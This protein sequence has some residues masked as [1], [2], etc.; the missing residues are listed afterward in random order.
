MFCQMLAA[1][2]EATSR[3]H[4]GTEAAWLY[5]LGLGARRSQDWI[6]WLLLHWSCLGRLFEFILL[7]SMVR[8]L[9]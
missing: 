5:Q 9:G 7:C 6:F 3:G 4:C 8:G 1:L 2:L